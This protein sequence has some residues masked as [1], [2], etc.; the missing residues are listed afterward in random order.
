MRLARWGDPETNNIFFQ[1]NGAMKSIN[2]LC[3]KIMNVMFL[4]SNKKQL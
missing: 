1:P 4:T 2:L 3:F